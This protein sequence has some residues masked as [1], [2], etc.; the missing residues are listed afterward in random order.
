MDLESD[1]MQEDV[2]PDGGQKS[3]SPAACGRR[4]TP[5]TLAVLGTEVEDRV[6]LVGLSLLMHL[7][8]QGASA[9]LLV[10]PR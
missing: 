10:A 2:G 8:L 4:G 5:T 9:S 6:V 1:S 3:S 7:G